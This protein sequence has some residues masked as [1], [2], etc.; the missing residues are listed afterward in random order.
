[1]KSVVML[2]V[3]CLKEAGDQHRVHIDRD[4]AYAEARIKEENLAFLGITLPN[5]EKGLLAALTRGWI[6]DD[7]FPGFRCR[8]GLPTFLSGF[9]RLIFDVDG[10]VRD[11]VDIRVIRSLRQVLLLVSKIELPCSEKRTRNAIQAYA[12]TDSSLEEIP[13]SLLLDFK[14][15]A[16]VLLA[17]Y[18]AEVE[19]TLWSGEWIPRHSSGALATREKYNERFG[20]RVWT[21]RLQAVFPWWDEVAT[22]Y[23]EVVSN[24][25]DFRILARDEET[26]SKVATI[27]KTMKGPRIIAEEPVW[28]QFVQQGILHAMTDTLKKPRFRRLA[29][30][31]SWLD[32][33]PN[34][35]LARVGSID[36]SFATL[37]LSEASDRV[38]LQLVEALLDCH[39]FLREA[40]L[41]SRSERATLYPGRV[42]TLKKFASMGSSLCFPIESMVFFVIEALAWAEVQG[43]VPSALRM[44]GLPRMRVYG[45]DLIVPQKV[46]QILS[47][48][49]EAYGLKV[50]TR[51]SFTTGPIR[52]SCG[53]DWYLGEDI[54]VFKLRHPVPDSKDQP[55]LID[56]AVSFHNHAYGAG[57]FGV[58]R[59]MEE[60]LKEVFPRLPHVPVGTRVV[61]LWSYDR[62]DAVKRSPGLQRD[63]YRTFILRQVKPVDSLNEYG[64]LR[65]FFSPHFEVREKEHLERDGR[66]RY[67]G[68]N[69]GWSTVPY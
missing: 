69:I 67:A 21:E 10:K 24:A 38:S 1:M 22:S 64:A 49:L 43:I 12:I 44:R 63:M 62:V 52:E 46:A 9:L 25:D 4:L 57:W 56:K 45:D 39:P 31:F 34:R 33:E 17:P 53:S 47:Q 48:R 59:E 27:P 66:S 13:R 16:R 40:V 26:P 15:A 37:D 42:V 18:L 54:S 61:A 11:D 23:K 2:W 29:D 5:Y 32:Q 6:G 50:N 28:N 60:N 7:L 41:A 3:A 51:K 19:A 35:D 36:G 65:K 14:D 20:N 58:A 68:V 8:G 55:E 30:I